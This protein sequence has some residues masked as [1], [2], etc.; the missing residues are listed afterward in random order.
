MNKAKPVNVPLVEHF[1][2]RTMQCP[3]SEEEKKE[4]SRVPYCTLFSRGRKSTVYHDLHKTKYCPCSWCCASI[5]VQSWQ[6]ALECSE[7]GIKIFE[8]NYQKRC[9][10][11]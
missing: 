5:L 9:L 6:R 4:M 3:T 8:G 11:W 10:C 2:L 1:K 7:M